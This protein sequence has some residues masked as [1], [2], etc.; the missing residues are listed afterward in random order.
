[1]LQQSDW[2]PHGPGGARAPSLPVADL[3]ISHLGESTF[4]D[5]IRKSPDFIRAYKGKQVWW[6]S[7]GISG[8]IESPDMDKQVELCDEAH[9]AAPLSVVA[10]QAQKAVRQ[11][12]FSFLSFSLGLESLFSAVSMWQ[13][14]G[15]VNTS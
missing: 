10:L 4:L 3:M 7:K 6:A 14:G 12:P 11:S 1:M 5:L 8:G 2:Q 15:D 13:T 9:T